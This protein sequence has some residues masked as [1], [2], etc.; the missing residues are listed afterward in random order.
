MIP[1][2]VART[3]RELNLKSDARFRF[4]RGV[5]P[6]SVKWGI[7]IATK[8]ILDLCGGETSNI[9]I[10]GDKKIPDKNIKYNFDRVM[11]P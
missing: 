3:G 9:T 2:S 1:I 11:S 4:E 6:H 10:A 5:D 8:M 7:D